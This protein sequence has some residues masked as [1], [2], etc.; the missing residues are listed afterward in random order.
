MPLDPPP[1]ILAL[2]GHDRYFCGHLWGLLG[3]GI[4]FFSFLL[5]TRVDIFSIWLVAPSHVF[6]HTRTDSLDLVRFYSIF[7]CLAHV[8]LY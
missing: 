4:F 6:K 3:V 8:A 5:V 2:G 7:V 1:T